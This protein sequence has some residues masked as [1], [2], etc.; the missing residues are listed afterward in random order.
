MLQ[1]EALKATNGYIIVVAGFLTNRDLGIE[2]IGFSTFIYVNSRQR[3]I[4]E[5]KL[6]IFYIW[7]VSSL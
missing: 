1:C 3:I 6:D 7:L 4:L 2:V 5:D